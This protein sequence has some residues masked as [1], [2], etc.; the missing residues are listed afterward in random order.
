V[1]AVAAA[2][3]AVS[4][5][6]PDPD[7]PGTVRRRLVTIEQTPHG[8]L[9]ARPVSSRRSYATRLLL[10]LPPHVRGAEVSSWV[11]EIS[12]GNTIRIDLRGV[13]VQPGHRRLEY[14]QG[15]QHVLHVQAGVGVQPGSLRLVRDSDRVSA[16]ELR[17]GREQLGG[18]PACLGDL[19]RLREN[20]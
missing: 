3:G 8:D 18:A 19:P 7:D 17:F 15:H 20:A 2:V 5:V 11:P 1:A 9:I 13:G 12:G 14:R 4:S 6:E 10:R 16:S